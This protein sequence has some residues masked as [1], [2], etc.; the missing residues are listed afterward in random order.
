M[1]VFEEQSILSK[2]NVDS[3]EVNENITVSTETP[4]I[5]IDQTENIITT[6]EQSCNVIYSLINDCPNNVTEA[7]SSSEWCMWKLAMQAE[8]DAIN[9]AGTWRVVLTPKNRNI[10]TYRWV[11]KKKIVD[12]RVIY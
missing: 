11:F 8:L 5:N 7:K 6:D 9:E 4:R 2:S 12:G 3:R 1:F 10:V